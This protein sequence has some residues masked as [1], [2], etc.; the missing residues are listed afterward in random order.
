MK[1]IVSDT[2]SLIVLEAL[3]TIK[4]LC[5]VFES[6]LIPQAV[7]N[8]L[9]AGSPNILQKIHDAG[10]MEVIRLEPS[11]QLAS[12]QVILDNGEAEAI[13][14]AIERQLPILIDERKGR[15]IAIQKQLVVTGFA[16][17]L[18]L[19]VKQSV[20][21]P[22]EAQQLLDQAISNRFRLS[23]KLYQQISAYFKQQDS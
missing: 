17:L 21:T 20:L 12:L 15:T 16:G 14:L 9:Y 18:I 2:T 22:T 5:S 6:I 7:L 3:H 8:E 4:L 19:A 10:C 1:V 23:N 13:T 11:E